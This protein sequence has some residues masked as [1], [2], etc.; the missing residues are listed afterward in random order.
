MM[1]DFKM[2][3]IWAFFFSYVTQN[4]ALLGRCSLPTFWGSKIETVHNCGRLKL[5]QP[6]YS[7]WFKLEQRTQLYLIILML[8]KRSGSGVFS[9]FC[10][11]STSRVNCLSGWCLLGTGNTLTDRPRPRS[12]SARM[13]ARYRTAI[14]ASPGRTSWLDISAFTPAKNRSSAGFACGPSPGATTWRPT[15]GL[16][17]VKNPSHVISVVVNS[18]GQT[19]KNDTPRSM[20]KPG[21]G[22]GQL[23]QQPRQLQPLQQLL[24][25][26]LQPVPHCR[27]LTLRPPWPRPV[28]P[29]HSRYGH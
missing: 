20:P 3:V 10:H 16:I 25:Q 1:I 5:T 21:V 8:L 7:A 23:P 18:P 2:K 12:T 28:P 6:V 27:Q 24:R 22:E 17:R 26:L 19:R 14:D 29:G 9:C 4:Q 11:R 15:S 13:P